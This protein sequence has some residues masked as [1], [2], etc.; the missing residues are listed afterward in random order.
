MTIFFVITITISLAGY[1]I[2]KISTKKKTPILSV[3]I[4]S[5]NGSEFTIQ[6]NKLNQDISDMEYVKLILG[7]L[8]KILYVIPIKDSNEFMYS[9]YEILEP[10]FNI[11]TL[12]KMHPKISII[13]GIP[14]GKIIDGTLFI[15]NKNTFYLN[16]R[17][18]NYPFERQYHYSFL[19]LFKHVYDKIG[20]EEKKVL[21][22]TLKYLSSEYCLNNKDYRSLKSLMTLP[23][24]AFINYNLK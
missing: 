17:I 24:E 16:S 6:L 14:K 7:F 8:A 4:G 10:N 9:F 20:D 18:P 21:I 1:I 22:G 15:T 13:E 11:N 19:S 23:N 5:E 12:L 3:K 2:I